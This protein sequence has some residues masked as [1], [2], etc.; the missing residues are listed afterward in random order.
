MIKVVK[1]VSY[2]QTFVLLGYLPLIYAI[3]M[4]EIVYFLSISSLKL[5]VQFSPDHMGYSVERM[6]TICLKSSV[7]IALDGC[8][9]HIW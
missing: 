4:S 9:A 3:Y 7:A 2:N 5:H 1:L 6:L 8:Y